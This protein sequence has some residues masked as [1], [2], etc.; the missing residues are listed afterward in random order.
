MWDAEG[1]RTACALFIMMP[2]AAQ[3]AWAAG[4]FNYSLPAG[5]TATAVD[6]AGNTYLTGYTSSATFPA[7]PGAFQT[8]YVGGQLGCNESVVV[9]G[10]AGTMPEPCNDGFVVKLD[11]TGAVVWATYIGGTGDDAA[12]EAIAVDAAG[13]VYIAGITA[14]AIGFSTSN[15]PTTSGS[16]FPVSATAGDGFVVKLNA[17]G[18][19]SEEHT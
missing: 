13:D 5:V 8:Q 12:G 7:T 2:S 14:P 10:S 15:F 4:G 16:A 17:A 19:R 9:G 11:A 1:M 3:W 6:A 18:T